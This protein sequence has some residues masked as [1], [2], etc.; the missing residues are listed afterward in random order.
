MA[1]EAAATH[2]AGG[3]APQA[4][5]WEKEFLLTWLLLMER[6]SDAHGLTQSLQS[7]LS[8]VN[9]SDNALLDARR[10]AD[11]LG[12]N[13]KTV[14]ELVELLDVFFCRDVAPA[15]KRAR[16][17]AQQSQQQ[18]PLDRY[19]ELGED[20]ASMSQTFVDNM[21]GWAAPGPQQTAPSNG[22]QTA[23]THIDTA[24]ADGLASDDEIPDAVFH[25]LLVANNLKVIA[26]QAPVYSAVVPA[27]VAQQQAPTATRGDA[28]GARTRTTPAVRS[29]SK[30]KTSKRGRVAPPPIV[31][32]LPR[33]SASAGST[34]RTQSQTPEAATKKDRIGKRAAADLVAEQV[35]RA[36]RYGS[37]REYLIR[38][39]GVTV[40]LWISRRKAPQQAKEL[41]DVFATE[42]RARE[43]ELARRAVAGQTQNRGGSGKR[44][45]SR[46]GASLRQQASGPNAA[47]EFYTVDHIVNHR[48]HYNKRQYLVRWENYD[49]SDDTWENSDKLRVD[50]PDI[51]DAYEAQLERDQTRAE[52]VQSAISELNRDTAAKSKPTTKK[53][54]IAG[55]ST[56]DTATGKT[57]DGEQAKEKRQ[58]I[59][60]EEEA[61]DN[62]DDGN[63]SNADDYQFDLE[64]AELEEFSEDEFV[65][66][67]HA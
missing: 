29:N 67:L 28:S 18:D 5:D 34:P 9:D 59:A 63:K 16:T 39:Q 7:A 66:R 27:R 33:R 52:A 35:L 65:D 64:E 48:T 45:A 17:A 8:Q 2:N 15:L 61:K 32:D 26:W 55:V 40:P 60:M 10:Q 11:A 53:R 38:W 6:L 4:A 51:I 1:V 49:A 54:A 50:V 30:G 56:E 14:S 12:A 19:L 36:R 41:I 57:P 3:S 62:G 46:T 23:E 24:A 25:D 44:K 37:A 20:G 21:S 31:T 13:D 42:L 22:Q 47:T 58:R 43:F